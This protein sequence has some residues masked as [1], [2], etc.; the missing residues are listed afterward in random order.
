MVKNHVFNIE[1]F[2]Q[3]NVD[4]Y[5]VVVNDYIPAGYSFNGAINPG[6]T[7]SGSTASI[8]IPG[9]IVLIQMQQF[10]YY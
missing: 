7:L 10:K 3:G 2:N 8:T 6:W 4:A 5:N 9:P 1:V